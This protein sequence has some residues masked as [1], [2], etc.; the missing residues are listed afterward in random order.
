MPPD[1]GGEGMHGDRA[2]P[3]TPI[4]HTG[5]WRSTAIT[6]PRVPGHTSLRHPEPTSRQPYGSTL[7]ANLDLDPPLAPA[8]NLPRNPRKPATTIPTKGLDRPRPFRKAPH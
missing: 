7:R 4:V 8:R 6:K 3:A 1:A 2:P 5:Q